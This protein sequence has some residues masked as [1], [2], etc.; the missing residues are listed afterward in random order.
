M[1]W[2]TLDDG[3]HVLIGPG[4]KV[5][6]QPRRNLL[7]GRRQG[8]AAGHWRLAARRR[9]GRRETQGSQSLKEQVERA[10]SAKGNRKQRQLRL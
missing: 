3:Q 1:G 2:V 10:R 9:S 6:C 4:G 8:A 7:G 5:L